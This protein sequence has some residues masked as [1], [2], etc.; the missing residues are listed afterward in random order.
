VERAAEPA[1]VLGDN[2]AHCGEDIITNFAL[3]ASCDLHGTLFA[4][5]TTFTW[6]VCELNST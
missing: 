3:P 6:I 1:L 2:T 4:E 5:S